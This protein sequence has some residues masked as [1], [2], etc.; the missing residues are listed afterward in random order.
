MTLQELKPLLSESGYVYLGHGTGRTGN[1]NQIVNSIFSEG[2]RTKNNSLYYTTIGLDTPTL[3]LREMSKDL[4]L[5]EPSI[6]GL[7]NQL[8]NWEH[9][10]SKK[11]IILKLP[12]EY[13]NEMG[14]VSDIDGEKYGAF[15]IEE[16]QQNGKITNYLN[17]KFILGCFD[18]EKQIVRLNP[19]YEKTLTSET[20]NQLRKGYEKSINKTKNRLD[21]LSENLSFLHDESNEIKQDDILLQNVDIDSFS[22]PD[23]EF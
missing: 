12:V 20:I 21:K 1:T 5:P 14:D 13:I 2:L 23:I 4:G 15:Y 18:A 17:P 6:E 3:E 22:F 16:V 9:Q 7:Q 19:K 10:D 11:I 8:S